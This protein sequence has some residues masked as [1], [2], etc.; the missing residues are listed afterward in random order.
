MRLDA[1]ELVRVPMVLARPFGAAHSTVSTRDVLLVHVSCE[2]LHGWSEVGVLPEPG[3]STE[4]T[5]LAHDVLVREMLPF[6]R[7]VSDVTS[8][9]VGSI[10]ADFQGRPASVAAIE[11]ALIDLE[12][13]RSHVSFADRIGALRDTVAAGVAV[14]LHDETAETVAEVRGYV[15]RGYARVKLKII[16]GMEYE[17]VS[18]VRGEVGDAVHLM[19]DANGSYHRSN[20]SLLAALDEFSLTCIEQPFAVDDL[21]THAMLAGAISTPICLDESISCVSDLRQALDIGACS[22][23]NLKWSRVGGVYEALRIHDECALAGVDLWIGG[24]L[25][26]GVGKAVDVA[27]SALPGVTMIGDISESSRYFAEDITEDFTMHHGRIA[28]PHDVGIGV[29]PLGERLLHMNARVY[30]A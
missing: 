30:S 8:A 29:V 28:V 24:M 1:I 25:S 5:D 6:L 3:Y 18:A 11:A 13:R 2:G 27:L 26:T 14:G 21:E 10:F 17:L 19:V 15:A 12:C 16:P 22:V 7:R 20:A 9:D 23:V 4:T